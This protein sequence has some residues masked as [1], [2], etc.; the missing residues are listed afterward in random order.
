MN[1][2]LTLNRHSRESGNPVEKQSLAQARQLLGFVRYAEYLI[3]L[4]SRFRGN[5]VLK[6]DAQ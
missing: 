5:D 2:T 6:G 3:P 1:F 4:D